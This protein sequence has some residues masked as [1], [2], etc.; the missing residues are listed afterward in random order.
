[1]E[2]GLEPLAGGDNVTNESFSTIRDKLLNR[3]AEHINCRC[4]IVELESVEKFRC[5]EREDE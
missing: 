3:S 2:A 1:M 5:I 4:V